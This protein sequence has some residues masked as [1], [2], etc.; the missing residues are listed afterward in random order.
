MQQIYLPICKHL[1]WNMLLSLG[2]A[3]D[4]VCTGGGDGDLSGPILH[5][6]CP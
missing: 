5:P 2:E 3:M 1:K 6:K 4:I